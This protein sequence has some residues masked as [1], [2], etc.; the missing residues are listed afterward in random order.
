ME[1]GEVLGMGID[2]ACGQRCKTCLSCCPLSSCARAT[3]YCP[4]DQATRRYNLPDRVLSTDT[5]TMR[6][7]RP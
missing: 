5:P 4:A 2:R 7:R 6:G 1:G 3:K